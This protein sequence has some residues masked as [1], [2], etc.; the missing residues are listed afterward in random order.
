M[1]P[2]DP[3]NAFE[4]AALFAKTITECGIEDQRMIM[5]AHM[6]GYRRAEAVDAFEVAQAAVE[7]EEALAL[8]TVKRGA[9]LPAEDEPAAAESEPADPDEGRVDTDDEHEVPDEVPEATA[10]QAA[11]R[12]LTS[13]S[14]TRLIDEC[15]RLHVRGWSRL[16][17]EGKGALSAAI[18]AK[19]AADVASA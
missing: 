10:E 14:M 15:K 9:K 4:L 5:Q 1:A 6:L 8:N 3:Q 12:A 18:L 11:M 16:R 13:L 17:N 19:R 7:A 2:P